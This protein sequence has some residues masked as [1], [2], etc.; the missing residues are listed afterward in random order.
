MALRV[1]IPNLTI[2]WSAHVAHLCYHSLYQLQAVAA[3]LLEQFEFSLPEDRPR[4]TRGPGGVMVPLMH[5]KRGGTVAAMP[6]H[7][8]IA[9]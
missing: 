6:L 5:E 8:S 4:I 1:S 3:E 9:A 2:P 7:V